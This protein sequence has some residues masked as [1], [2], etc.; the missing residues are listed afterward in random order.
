MKNGYRRLENLI[1]NVVQESDC[2]F[3][4]KEPG[5]LILELTLVQEGV[6]WFEERGFVMESIRVKVTSDQK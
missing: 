5:D 6:T 1:K 2:P 4:L 3:S